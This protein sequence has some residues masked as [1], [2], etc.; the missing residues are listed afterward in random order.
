MFKGIS[1]DRERESLKIIYIYI[2]IY[3][4][5]TFQVLSITQKKKIQKLNIFVM[6]IHG[7]L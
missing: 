7:H 4:Y 6:A 1:P 2:Y 3:I 5:D